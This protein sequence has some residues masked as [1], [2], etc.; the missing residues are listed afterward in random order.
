MILSVLGGS[1]L[2]HV[3]AILAPSSCHLHVPTISVAYLGPWAMGRSSAIAHWERGDRPV[4]L[5]TPSIDLLGALFGVSA[6][7]VVVMFLCFMPGIFFV[8]ALFSL[9]IS[10][11]LTQ[12]VGMHLALQAGGALYFSD[13]HET[14]LHQCCS[15]IVL[16]KVADMPTIPENVKLVSDW[17]CLC[18]RMTRDSGAASC[19]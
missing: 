5:H 11:G 2:C 10:L 7:F 6:M 4:L 15:I 8:Y 16:A 18:T 17:Y 19:R 13:I 1:C 12:I 9:C 14:S 3:V